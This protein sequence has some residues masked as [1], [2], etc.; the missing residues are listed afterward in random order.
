MP[1]TP[2]AN[3]AERRGRGRP[4]GSKTVFL[5]QAARAGSVAAKRQRES[6]T[7]P[8]SPDTGTLNDYGVSD[9]APEYVEEQEAEPVFTGYRGKYGMLKT[10]IVSSYAMA[11]LL[12]GGPTSPDGALFLTNAEKIADAW[13]AW[14]KA[15]PRYMRIVTILWGGPF[16]TLALAHSPLIA[17]IAANHNIPIAKYLNPFGQLNRLRMP[18]VDMRNQSAQAP[19]DEPGLGTYVPVGPDAPTDGQG[20]PP[21]YVDGGLRV[22]PDEGIPSEID[23]QLRQVARAQ[24]IPYEQLRDAWLLDVAQQRIAHNQHVNTPGTLG[25]PVTK[26]G[27]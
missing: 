21:Q 12:A 2:P 15:D 9:T 26:P 7:P 17:G 13:I 23:V 25:Q 20:P 27:A 19:Q 10:N 4:K 8:P 24:N 5:H 22:F 16:M 14:G 1:D 11:G 18:V 6:L 3:R